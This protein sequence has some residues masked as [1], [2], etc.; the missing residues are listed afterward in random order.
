MSKNKRYIVFPIEQEVP[1]VSLQGTGW[2]ITT[3]NPTHD[4]NQ[5]FYSRIHDYQNKGVWND[6]DIVYEHHAHENYCV[7]P[8][9]ARAKGI[10]L[11][12]HWQ[13]MIC[14]RTPK[15]F[16]DVRKLFPRSY[17]CQAREGFVANWLY[18]NKEVDSMGYGDLREGMLSWP[19]F[20]KKLGG[21]DKQN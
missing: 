21:L 8:Y 15:T 5:R 16:N 7:E 18:I 13:G 19:Q 10:K 4:D 3:N 9:W 11:T 14:F 6:N 17:I 2:V 12:P 20:S 1:L